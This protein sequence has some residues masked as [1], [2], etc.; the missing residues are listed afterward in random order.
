MNLLFGRSRSKPEAGEI[1]RLKQ[2]NLRL[3]EELAWRR[4]ALGRLEYHAKNAHFIATEHPGKVAIA[5]F[6][7]LDELPF[8]PFDFAQ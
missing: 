8:D 3:Q 5:V 6:S 7:C 2:E 1:L 4:S